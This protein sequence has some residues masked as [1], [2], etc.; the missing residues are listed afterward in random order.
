M[1]LEGFILSEISQKKDK[2]FGISLTCVIENQKKKVIDTE[3]KFVI[4]RIGVGLVWVKKEKRIKT[5]T[6][7]IIK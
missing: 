4:V 7:P 1:D 3:S 5:Y 2:Y 6:F